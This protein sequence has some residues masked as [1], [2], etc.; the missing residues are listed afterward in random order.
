MRHVR[1]RSAVAIALTRA[2]VLIAAAA[3]AAAV[4]IA[5]I[6]SQPAHSA[7]RPELEAYANEAM[8]K[9]YAESPAAQELASQSRGIL[10]FPRVWKGGMGLGGE[11][12]EGVLRVGGRSVEYYQLA[13]ASVGL[14]L[15]LQRK[16]VVV[17]FLDGES[18]AKFRQS[19][20]WKAGVDG[21]I[22]IANLGAGTSMD[23]NTAQK[24]II[25]FVISNKGLMYNLSFEGTKL[26]RIEK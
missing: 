26:T 1:R 10:V 15:G 22:A 13:G 16:A 9:L 7:T 18:L 21:S 14:Q 24:P 6:A 8:K 25:G 20:G 12:G 23:T 2:R 3:V 4:L 19:E 11:V 5:S 17:M